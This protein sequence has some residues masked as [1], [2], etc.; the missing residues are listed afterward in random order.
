[1][2]AYQITIQEIGSLPNITA[3]TFP[4]IG[5]RMPTEFGVLFDRLGKQRRPAGVK[6]MHRNTRRLRIIDEV[7]RP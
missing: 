3:N 7:D 6:D 1:M 4:N 5:R 2:A